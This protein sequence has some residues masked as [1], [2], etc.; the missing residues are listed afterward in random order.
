MGISKLKQVVLPPFFFFSLF[1]FMKQRVSKH[2]EIYLAHLFSYR[3]SNN[4]LRMADKDEVLN[5]SDQAQQETLIENLQRNKTADKHDQWLSGACQCNSER[6]KTDSL[7]DREKRLRI[8]H[9]YD[10][11]VINTE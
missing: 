9:N 5:P 2:I 11:R 1:P 4:Q 7:S 8:N 6:R 10:A 3:H